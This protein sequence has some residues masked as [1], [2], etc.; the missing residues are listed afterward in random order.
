MMTS[1]NTLHSQLVNP[2]NTFVD[3][4]AV[5]MVFSVQRH[6]LRRIRGVG[7]K[8]IGVIKARAPMAEVTANDEN[9]RRVCEIRC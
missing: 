5:W 2:S 8:I 3:R 7:G 1:F 6:T 9:I 4:Y